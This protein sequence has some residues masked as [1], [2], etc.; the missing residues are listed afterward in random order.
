[1][2]TIGKAVVGGPLLSLSFY[3]TI[4][5]FSDLYAGEISKSAISV[6]AEI[7]PSSLP[8]SLC[9]SACLSAY[10]AAHFA[11]S[12]A[13]PS[14]SHSSLAAI[15]LRSLI[16]A[17]QPIIAFVYYKSFTSHTSAFKTKQK[18]ICLMY[19]FFPFSNSLLLS[20]KRRFRGISFA[21]SL[22]Y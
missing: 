20:V 19:H 6:F 5:L 8:L 17:Q 4:S 22:M 13:R 21:F 7:E 1:M 9:R 14:R 2:Q 3:C 16:A 18:L 12:Y 11:L 10:S 15:T